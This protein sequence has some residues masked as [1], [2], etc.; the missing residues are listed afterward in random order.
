MSSVDTKLTHFI[1][2]AMELLRVVPQRGSTEVHNVLLTAADALTQAGRK[3]IFTP[4]LGQFSENICRPFVVQS[5]VMIIFVTPRV[6][7]ITQEW[8]HRHN[9]LSESAKLLKVFL[10][11]SQFVSGYPLVE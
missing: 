1:L 8:Y 3:D 4:C 10:L 2:S 11:E 6:T 9:V 7:Q 5:F